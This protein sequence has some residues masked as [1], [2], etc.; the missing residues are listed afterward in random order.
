MDDGMPELED[1]DDDGMPELEGEND[2]RNLSRA[3][4][5]LIS[6]FFNDGVAVLTSHLFYFR[7]S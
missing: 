3:G 7:G 4:E 5:S 1:Y 6:F 2:M